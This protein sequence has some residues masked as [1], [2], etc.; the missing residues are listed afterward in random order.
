[1]STANANRWSRKGKV[2]HLMVERHLRR[3]DVS[4][5][6]QTEKSPIFVTM[7][8]SVLRAEPHVLGLTAGFVCVIP[9][10][11]PLR[12]EE[13]GLNHILRSYV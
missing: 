5:G 9:E 7:H 8:D 3:V 10:V 11:W 13:Y 4:Y 6:E 12:C 2:F 1:M